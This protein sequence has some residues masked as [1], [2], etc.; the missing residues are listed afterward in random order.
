MYRAI[1]LPIDLAHEAS[2][3]KALPTALTLAKTFDS[4]LHVLTVVADV[5]GSLVSQYFPPDYEIKITHDAQAALGAF[6]EANFPEK[7]AHLAVRQGSVYREIIMYAKSH[8]CDLIVMASHRPE[9]SDFLIGPN[10]EQ[11]MRHTNCSV[12]VVRS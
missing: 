12:M 10:A 1:L 6:A 3:T 4:E 11:V 8:A 5:R 7:K 2:W 9:V